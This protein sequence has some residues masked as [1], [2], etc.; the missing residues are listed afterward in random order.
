MN[1]ELSAQR[2][3]KR[4]TPADRQAAANHLFADPAPEAVAGAFGVIARARR[5][6]PQAVR[7]MTPE[8]QARAV[9]SI[10]DTGEALAASLLVALHL[11]ER[12]DLLKAFLDAMSLPHE[13]GIL[14]EE[15][16]SAPTPTAESLRPGIAALA[17]FPKDQVAM[18]LNVLF[19][20]DPERWKALADA[21]VS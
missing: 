7:A 15:A 10:L 18:Y 21:E 14:K 11:G 8:A 5:M 9:A 6:R 20:Q 4:L 3:W 13:N 16:E 19:L 17:A 1:L 12:R 2:L